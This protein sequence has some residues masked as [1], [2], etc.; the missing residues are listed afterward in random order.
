[1]LKRPYRAVCRLAHALYVVTSLQAQQQD[2]PIK[3]RSVNTYRACAGR[4]TELLK[5]FAIILITV[6]FA[7]VDVPWGFHFHKETAW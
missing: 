7:S 3:R 5:R 6:S 2:A 1:M 4:R